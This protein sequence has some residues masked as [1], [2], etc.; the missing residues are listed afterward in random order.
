MPIAN[1]AT[2]AYTAGHFELTIDGAATPGFLKSVEGGF[3]KLNSAD[4]QG[5]GDPIKIKHTTT[6]EVEPMTVEVGMSQVNALWLWIAQSWRREFSR[7]DGHIIHA[8]QNYKAQLQHNFYGAL[9]EEV[10]VPACDAGSKEGLFMKI[11]LRP[12]RVEILDGDKAKITGIEKSTQKL[13]QASAFRLRLDNGLDTSRVN[14]ID[15][16]TIKQGIKTVTAGRGAHTG[17][18]PEL[19]PT[20][21]DFPDLKIH[22]TMAYAGPILEWYKMV[23]IEG[24][25]ETD[26]ETT[27]AIEFLSPDR[28]KVLGEINLY[29]VG[30]KGFSMGKSEA[31]SDQ[32][33]RCS[34]DLYVSHMGLNDKDLRMQLE[35]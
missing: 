3:V 18:F 11:K 7:K 13:W 4:V 35:S 20:K 26:F 14:K 33:K 17:S 5:G 8:D 28:K 30:I 12:E 2:R 6:R 32:V 29:G 16:F 15:A 22:M 23:V 10:T 9:I 24:Q 31:N 27:G 1:H 25:R 34:F 19:E 21:I